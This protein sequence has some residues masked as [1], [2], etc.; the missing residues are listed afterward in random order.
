MTQQTAHV[1]D[2][3]KG[4]TREDFAIIEHCGG[5]IL[6]PVKLHR[7]RTTGKFDEEPAYLQ[8]L[9]PIE[10][11]EAKREALRVFAEQGFVK[12]D[13]RTTD[14]WTELEMISQVA[15]ALR[16][17]K[18]SADGIHYAK[19]SLDTLLQF[20]DTGISSREIASLHQ[21]L[22]MFAKLEDPRLETIDRATVIKVAIAIAEVGNLSP[23]VAI[24]G[25]ELDTCVIGMAA[26]LTE[27]LTHEFS[28]PSLASSNK[29][30]SPKKKSNTSSTAK[31]TSAPAAST[32]SDVMASSDPGA[33][34]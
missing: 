10:T 22:T 1:E 7:L 18:P 6:W 19:F 3:L 20:K 5:R 9:D 25:S 8:V 15:I 4:K 2:W 32:S 33:A 12:D 23:L 16:E 27:C 17:P 13:E 24:A 26:I 21:Q 28:L 34:K 11:M 30:R 29:E 31:P 14:I